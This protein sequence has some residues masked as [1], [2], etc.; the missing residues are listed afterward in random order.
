MSSDHGLGWLHTASPLCW[1]TQAVSL[2]GYG[3]PIALSTRKD[4]VARMGV[5]FDKV[6]R[7]REKAGLSLQEAADKAGF[8]NRQRWFQIETGRADLRISTLDAMAKALNV[9][10]ADLLT[11]K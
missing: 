1:P 7:L 3:E 11:K 9:S 6:K 4:T 10:V 5:D 8:P 2:K